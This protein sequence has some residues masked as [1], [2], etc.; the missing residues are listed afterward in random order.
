MS[1]TERATNRRRRA[2]VTGSRGFVGKHLVT[3]LNLQ[4][5]EVSEFNLRH[6][7]DVRYYDKVRDTI[8]AC[9]PNVIFHLAAQAAPRESFM[10]PQ[11]ALQVNAVGS[12]NILEA[13]RQLG[14]QTTIHLASTS[15]VYGP[16]NNDET[17]T[18]H[19]RS[20]YAVGK[21]AMDQ[22][23]QMY[24][25]AYGMHIVITRAFNHTGPGRG[26][27]Y[28]E[29]HFARQIAEYDAGKRSVI[30]HGDLAPIRNYTDVRDVVRAYVMAI[31]LGSG[32]Y[33]ICSDSNL[34]MEEVMMRLAELSKDHVVPLEQDQALMRPNDFSF[35]KPSCDKF[36]SATGWTPEFSLE[37][38][39]SD[40]LD[41]W[42]ERI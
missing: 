6:R 30:S 10:N 38:T 36:R 18:M 32:V 7:Q 34:S 25:S 20:P 33:N 11:R 19:P 16:G 31:D 4:G 21:A 1:A 13:V 15:E 35:R 14:Y 42:R 29:S 17:A 3:E 9:K 23:G 40:L 5:W 2:L 8:E 39:L 41:Y 22:L 26:E 24:A 27:E 28:A 12:L 37:K